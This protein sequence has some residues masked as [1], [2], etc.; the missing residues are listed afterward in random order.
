MSPAPALMLKDIARGAPFDD[1]NNIL[2]FDQL[3]QLDQNEMENFTEALGGLD[4]SCIRSYVKD[5]F[6]K[7]AVPKLVGRMSRTGKGSMTR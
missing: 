2:E 1:F 7:M 4:R 6:N 5:F 3:I